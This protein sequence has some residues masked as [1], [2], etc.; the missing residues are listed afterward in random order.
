MT[1][2]TGL[3]RLFAKIDTN[4]DGQ[5]SPIEL[6]AALSKLD[7]TPREVDDMMLQ[8]MAH[9][10][11]KSGTIDMKES[12]TNRFEAASHMPPS[13]L[14]LA[15]LPLLPSFTFCCYWSP[16]RAH[17]TLGRFK[18]VMKEI[19]ADRNAVLNQNKAEEALAAEA[20]AAEEAL[21]AERVA[22]PAA[23]GASTLA[24]EDT[25]PAKKQEGCVMQ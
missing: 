7:A 5:I 19:A 24:L 10:H 6:R 3:E 11:D 21:A 14:L 22:A 18:E 15:E 8:I 4:P 13:R 1:R 2:D 9:D 12:Q 17:R 25:S 16:F 23:E 20:P